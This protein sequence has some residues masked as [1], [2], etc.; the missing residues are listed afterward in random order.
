[1]SNEQVEE[2][3]ICPIQSNAIIGIMNTEGKC[4]KEKCGWW[5]ERTYHD[6]QLG[7]VKCGNCAM[8][9]MGEIAKEKLDLL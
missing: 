2:A 5:V 4:L 9:V 8:K 7:V 6:A 1:M 3:K